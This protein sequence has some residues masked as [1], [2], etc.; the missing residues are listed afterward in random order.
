METAL[1]I[2]GVAL[3]AGTALP[4]WR[5]GA[6]WIRIFDFPRVQILAGLVFV[7]AS[8]FLLNGFEGT[9]PRALI[10]ALAASLLYQCFMMFP[11]TRLSRHQVQNS[12]RARELAGGGGGDD[13]CRLLFA[14]VL[15]SNREPERLRRIIRD[16][17]PD[18][19]LTVETDEWWQT[20]L[21]EFEATHPHVVH[22]PL[23][24]TYGM[25]LYSRHPL[26]ETEIKFLVEDDVPSIHTRLRLPSGTELWL[27]CLHPRPPFPTEA[28]QS[29][30][31]DAELLIV[32]RGIKRHDEPVI[33]IGDLNDVAWSHT[34]YLFQDVSGLLDPRIGRG[35][36]NTFHAQIPLVRFPLDHVFHTNHFR[37]IELKRLARFGSD[38]FPVLITLSY[39]PD[40]EIVQEEPQADHA[41]RE[42]A[43]E[44]IAEAVA[45]KK[46]SA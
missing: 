16:A 19:I 37:L 39:E 28:K 45:R 34:N 43:S 10:V 13:T 9:W 6:W 3:V 1:E 15:M 20:Q 8:Y 35:F 4:L 25:L 17:A 23:D 36:F 21:R 27:H 42:E 14:N 29:T 2:F 38:H 33:V 7:L 32:G 24:N 11:Y 26:S 40:A 41:Q 18:V 44:K 46:Q 12:R 5:G 30:E 31:R 22:H